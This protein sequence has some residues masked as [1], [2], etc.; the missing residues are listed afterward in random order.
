MPFDGLSERSN[1]GDNPSKLWVR[2]VLAGWKPLDYRMPTSPRWKVAIGM[3]L[4]KVERAQA[5]ARHFLRLRVRADCHAL[6]RGRPSEN[7]V[8]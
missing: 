4:S 8:E 3:A 1:S 2:A 7:C 5:E 6:A